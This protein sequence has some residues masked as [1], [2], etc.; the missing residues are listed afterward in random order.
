VNG[1]EREL[2]PAEGAAILARLA[3]SANGRPARR[4]PLPQQL[5]IAEARYR[6]LIEQIPAVTF[7]ASLEGGLSD[8]YVSP[9]VEAL[10]AQFEGER[11]PP[12]TRPRGT[13]GAGCSLLLTPGLSAPAPETVP[14]IL[15]TICSLAELQKTVSAGQRL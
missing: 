14:E 5:A 12:A 11:L 9:Q 10:L 4:A 1:D 2:G 3:R 7:M 6:A 8:V 13:P 15:L